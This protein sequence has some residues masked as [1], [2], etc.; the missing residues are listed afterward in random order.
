MRTNTF[1]RN[2][3][4]FR[5]TAMAAALA[6]AGM[7]FGQAA[8]QSTPETDGAIRIVSPAESDE[9]TGRDVAI[10]WEAPGLTIVAAKDAKTEDELHAHFIVDGAAEVVEGA[11][12]PA[13]CGVLHTAA[14]PATLTNLPPGDHTVQLVIANPGHVPVEGLDRPSVSFTVVEDEEAIRITSPEN[15]AEVAGPDVEIGWEA[16]GLTIVPAKD[17]QNEDDLHAHFI[18]D[19]AY[20]IVEGAPIPVE[21]EGI[22]HSAANPATTLPTTFP[23]AARQ[24]P[25]RASPTVSYPKVENVVSA[26]QNPVPASATTPAG[27]PPRAASPPTTPSTNDPTTLTTNVPHGRTVPCRDCTHRSTT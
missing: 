12:L 24:W 25:C 9:V 13:Q 7:T 19:N 21:T 6:I 26:P 4:W 8:A 22:L 3:A 15:C 10:A 1:G 27:S 17:A 14:N 2:G 23:V 11:P 5:A 20:E 18:V 16:P